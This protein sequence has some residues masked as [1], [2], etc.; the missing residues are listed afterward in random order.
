LGSA[1]ARTS[2]GF[3]VGALVAVNAIGS[4]TI[5]DGPHFWAAPYERDGE[6][7]GLGLPEGF[8]AEHLALQLKGAPAPP[9]LEN[10]TIAIVATDATLSK[11]Q[12]KRLAVVAHDGMA[13]ALRPSHAAMDGDLVFAAATGR[14]GRE[15]GLLD[16]VEI[17][18]LAADC[19]AR[20]IAR[21]IYSAGNNTGSGTSAGSK[22]GW[23]QRF[24]NQNSRHTS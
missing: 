15:P 8:A 5:G 10:T 22:P 24:V 14:A 7:G 23:Q 6:F 21:A 18:A 1:S 9:K 17:G 20:A 11:G 3:I 4:A 19:L 16:Q 13:R 12:A 2:A